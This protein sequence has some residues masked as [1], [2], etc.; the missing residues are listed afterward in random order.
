MATVSA[1]PPHP[2]QAPRPIAQRPVAPAPAP[3]PPPIQPAVPKR[4]NSDTVTAPAVASSS[5]VVAT[6]PPATTPPVLGACSH[7]T[8]SLS[9]PNEASQL[10]RIRLAVRYSVKL[11]T[12]TDEPDAKRRKVR[13]ALIPPWQDMREWARCHTMHEAD[14]HLIQMLSPRCTTCNL[15][16]SRPVLCLECG[17]ILCGGILPHHG[18][19]HAKEHA[20]K[21]RHTLCKLLVSHRRWM[22]RSCPRHAKEVIKSSRT[23]LMCSLGL[24]REQ[25]FVHGL[26]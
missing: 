6:P 26:L 18:T 25:H 15:A 22:F 2:A 17:S 16:L 10:Q 12:L 9:G 19:N 14:N 20:I 1:L 11:S 7:L 5:L 21:H 23:S 8:A 13:S 3:H 24:A 4:L